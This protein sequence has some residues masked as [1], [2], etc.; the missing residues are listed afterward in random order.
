MNT[1]MKTWFHIHRIRKSKSHAALPIQRH[2]SAEV[3]EIW[4]ATPPMTTRMESAARIAASKTSSRM[5]IERYLSAPL[6]DEPASVPAIDAA[7]KNQTSRN[8]GTQLPTILR[9]TH[10]RESSLDANSDGR[11]TFYTSGSAAESTATSHSA[12]SRK[13]NRSNHHHRS[14]THPRVPE[15]PKLITSGLE[16]ATDKSPERPTTSGTVDVEKTW[17]EQMDNFLPGYEEARRSEYRTKAEQEIAQIQEKAK[18]LEE[19]MRRYRAERES[20]ASPPSRVTDEMAYAQMA[21]RP[22]LAWILGGDIS[23]AKSIERPK[24]SGSVLVSSPE[25]ARSPEDIPERPS[26]SG[27]M[28]ETAPGKIPRRT[29]SH[30][31][32]DERPR[33]AHADKRNAML[34]ERK[35]TRRPKFYCTFCQKRFHSRLEWV[36]HEQTLHMPEELWVCCPRIGEFPE[37]CPFC[38]KSHPSPSHLADHNYLSCQEKP[39]S[40][41]TFSRKDHF[42]QH[43]SQVHKVNTWQKPLRLTEL[44]EAWRHPLP[45]K[46][47]HQALHCGF[48]GQTFTTYAERTEHVSGHFLEGLDM[49]SWWNGRVNHDIDQLNSSRVTYRNPDPPHR[50]CYCER[51]YANL[52]AAQ[53]LHPVCTMWSCSFLP[54]MQYTIYPAGSRENIE[55]VCCYCN[56]TLVK[57]AGRV[58]GSVL[59]EHISQ[60]NFRNCNQR[61]YFSGQRFRQHLQDSHKT[62]YDG[63]LFA[64]WTLLLKSSKTQKPS[65]FEQIDPSTAIRRAYTDP[66]AAKKEEATPQIPRANFMDLSETPQ[67]PSGRR[68]RRKASTLSVP[69]K[70]SR[71]VRS[72][73][74]FFSRAAT[75]DLVY[76]SNASPSPRFPQ[77]GPRSPKGKPRQHK[78]GFPVSSL[79]VDAVNT[80]PRFYRRRLDASTRNRLY[81]R[82]QDDGPLSKNSQRLFR[83]VP[84]S[85]LGGLVLHSSL[86]GTTPARMTNSVDIYS[87]H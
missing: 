52:A 6:E 28:V 37:R 77:N 70:P 35:P 55:A 58:K 60:H 33:K 4:R 5:S 15:L 69:E 76:G 59:K 82:D 17:A 32:L 13:V 44:L 3:D 83:K 87:L 71:E 64:G 20:P 9:R 56:E 54:G 40:E 51:T 7:L 31:A 26:T 48:C 74:Q 25:D 66:G 19:K 1:N 11:R 73:T 39:L 80:C 12:A 84:G 79:P 16:D 67:K 68:L 43:I 30:G 2:D 14:K 78:P 86:V 27:T 61:L 47:G 23:D 46:D 45:L 29:R 41:R 18:Q 72:S 38:A 63:S 36:R 65:V 42:L 85:L 57:G 22:K 49:M 81:V 53:N 50:C 62:N 34:Y 75:I 10:S 24:S 21:A 8:R